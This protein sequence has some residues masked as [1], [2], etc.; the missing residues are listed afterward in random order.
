MKDVL[1]SLEPYFDTINENEEDKL[2]ELHAVFQSDFIDNTFS[3][4]GKKLVV[5]RHVYIPKKD[6]LP[7]HFTRYFEKFV[8]IITREDKTK[9]GKK[10]SFL[11]DRA[12]RI[13][14][15]KPILEHR[16]DKRISYF[17]FT[18]SND[19]IRDYYWYKQKSYMVV[20]EEVLPDY[21][22]ITGFCVDEKNEKYFLRKERNNKA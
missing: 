15:I 9:Q 11:A 7:A 17:Q 14:W 6:G 10:R 22:L 16:N 8:H 2:D 18:E 20:L 13:H 1:A 3:I 19:A 5:K 21:Y 4:D 12:K